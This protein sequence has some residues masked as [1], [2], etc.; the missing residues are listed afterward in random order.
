MTPEVLSMFYVKIN[1]STI[2]DNPVAV[3]TAIYNEIRNITKLPKFTL[4]VK[5]CFLSFLSTFLYLMVL[6]QKHYGEHAV[7]NSVKFNQ[8]W[9]FR[10]KIIES[11]QG[12]NIKR[13]NW[14]RFFIVSWLK[15][16][17]SEDTEKNARK[18]SVRMTGRS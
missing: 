6:E 13:S 3:Q 9:C 17:I 18:V 2:S 15:S 4:Y 7:E 10:S 8:T 5:K 1:N 11:K 12:N 16:I 14:G